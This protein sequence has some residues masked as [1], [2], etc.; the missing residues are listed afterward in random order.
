M[1]DKKEIQL[2]QLPFKPVSMFFGG[3]RPAVFKKEEGGYG[4][5]IKIGEAWNSGGTKTTWDYFDLDKTGLIIA[6]PRG[7]A[8]TY[9]KKVRIIDID[10]MVLEYKEKIIS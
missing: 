2:S 9:N 5:R 1:E 8:K 6:S 10:K 4:I 3:L 7:Y